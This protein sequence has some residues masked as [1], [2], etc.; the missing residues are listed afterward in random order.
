MIS[1]ISDE[2]LQ[3]R[4]VVYLRQSTLK[5]VVEHTE[6]TK[7][8]YN[9]RER[10]LALGW[11]VNSVDVV[12]EDLGRSGSTTEGRSGFRKLSEE[13]ARG[14]V[15]AVLALDVSRLARSSADWHRLLDLCGVADVLIADEQSIYDPRDHNDRLLLGIK[16][17]MSEAELTWMRLRLRGARM[18]KARRG[19][20]HLP[21]P[22]GYEWDPSTQRFRLDAD[23]GVQRAIKLI[24]ERFRIDRSA[25]GVARYFVTH[26]L[27]IPTRL[28]GTRDL[29]WSAPRPSRILHILAN[30]TYAG[31]YVYGRRQRT[32]GLV[33]GQIVHRTCRIPSDAWKIVHRERHPAY[34]PWEEYVSNQKTLRG[35]RPGRDAPER[36]GAPRAGEALLQGIVLCGRCGGRMNTIYDGKQQH[37]RYS[38]HSPTQR[39]EA[40]RLC[41][42]VS[43]KA[44][45]EH[46]AQLVLAVVQ[47]PEVELGL[48]VVRETE[49]QAKQLD[50]QWRLR[51][52]RA[53]YEARLAERRYKAVDPDNRIVARALEREWEEKLAELDEVE[54]K[55]AE[56]RRQKK[57]DLDTR[58]RAR[59]IALSRSLPTVW[60]APSTTMAERK[61]VV[62]TLIREV[63]LTPSDRPT[64][65]TRVDVLWQTGATDSATIDRQ[66]PGRPTPKDAA[67]LIRQ[68]VR[69]GTRATEI[70]E[71][72]NE[73][74]LVTASGLP[75]T[76]T[77]IHA[78]C[79]YNEVRWPK[80]MP[81][82]VRQPDRR[83]DGL[84]SLRGVAA[85][86]ALTES[87]A[88]HWVKRGWLSPAEGGSKGHPS[89][90][91]LDQV[92][93]RRLERF[94]DAHIRDASR[95]KSQT[96]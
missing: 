18:S 63:C 2:H 50:E 46:V 35:N 91:R 95:Q 71:Q 82:S 10:A 19:E 22:V 58:D 54:R 15:G 86:L 78:H 11:P 37:A 8:Q 45:D 44:I 17:T 73:R 66:L 53:R 33:D 64:R 79:L 49:R 34:L 81:S 13:I 6:S 70:A 67:R 39:G 87:A 90:F 27:K 59:L 61:N 23:E 92:T 76:N 25:H 32:V 7:R 57:V 68:L 89:W 38:C 75:W 9:L 55:I 60:A 16:G 1:K 41:W 30:P 40:M 69:E 84:Y 56:G 47:P 85:R 36:H 74:G 42:S 24:F 83:R 26:D 52:E 43:A 72:L 3:R 28:L 31:A 88:R 62:R 93:I 51:V 5:Q 80:R 96:F 4:A 77:L 12:D 29:S 65:G 94:R 21:P 20:Y 48:A 14:S